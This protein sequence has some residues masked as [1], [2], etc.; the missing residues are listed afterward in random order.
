MTALWND[1]TCR[2]GGKA[3]TCRRSQNFSGTNWVGIG[4]NWVRFH[5]LKKSKLEKSPMFN[6]DWHF[7]NWVRLVVFV[8]LKKGG[9]PQAQRPEEC[10]A[11]QLGTATR[12]PSHLAHGDFSPIPLRQGFRGQGLRRDR[13]ATMAMIVLSSPATLTGA[14]EKKTGPSR[15][16][17][18]F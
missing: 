3:A 18:D 9:W 8:F 14:E 10:N 13:G 11:C 15:F 12:R 16:N 1:A 4:L 7:L 2:V 6:G 5:F 17:E